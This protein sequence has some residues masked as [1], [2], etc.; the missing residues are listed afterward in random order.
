MVV[1]TLPPEFLVFWERT[2]QTVNKSL[3]ANTP[4]AHLP[5][6]TAGPLMKGR[7]SIHTWLSSSFGF[8]IPSKVEVQGQYYDKML[9]QTRIGA[10]PS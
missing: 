10:T 4:Q 2:N 1:N 5:R 8:P 3:N 9:T 7:A 6:N